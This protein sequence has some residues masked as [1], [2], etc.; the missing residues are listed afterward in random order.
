VKGFSPKKREQVWF[1]I[2]ILDSRILHK[3]TTYDTNVHLLQADI[4][5]VREY[6]TVLIFLLAFLVELVLI[7]LIVVL[8]LPLLLD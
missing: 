4:W 7:I 5:K 3:K 6:Q 1:K 2:N 8:G